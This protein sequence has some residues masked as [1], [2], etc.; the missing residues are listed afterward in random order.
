[1]R[2]VGAVST[3]PHLE[4]A[5]G[6][7]FEQLVQPQWCRVARH[8]HQDFHRRS[9]DLAVGRGRSASN[10]LVIDDAMIS[11]RH[12]KIALE[13]GRFLAYD[14][15]STN[16]TTVEGTPLTPGHGWPLADG[17]ELRLG[18]TRLLF[19]TDGD[20][21]TAPAPKAVVTP[22]SPIMGESSPLLGQGVTFYLVSPAGERHA[23]ASEMLLG[24]ALTDD[25]VVTGDGV[26]AQ[27]ARITVRG[28]HVYLEDLDT[29]GGTQVNG[30]KIPPSYAV[31]LHGGDTVTI[32]GTTLALE[33]G[34]GA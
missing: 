2:D 30:S 13:G 21:K 18:Q 1:M 4:P 23:L 16:G 28:E 8:A 24:R 31:A 12:L 27:H 25:I 6:W 19:S 17:D 11:K 29:P 14:E 10:D 20:P 26:S 3:Q 7:V 9:R 33:R 5:A 15:H 34:G 22:R 32:G